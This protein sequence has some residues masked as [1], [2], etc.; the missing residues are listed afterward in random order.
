MTEDIM[1]FYRVRQKYLTVFE[2]KHRFKAMWK[3]LLTQVDTVP[4]P[5][6]IQTALSAWKRRV[7][8]QA[9]F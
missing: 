4:C 6:R 7:A 5:W 1:E 8:G 3:N 2:M 9:G